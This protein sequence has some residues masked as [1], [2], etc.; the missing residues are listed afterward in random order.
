MSVQAELQ[1]IYDRHGRLTP[2]I[3]VEEASD[4]DHP[5]HR[6]FEWDDSEAARKYR[7]SQAGSLIRSVTVVVE[8]PG[9]S[10]PIEVRAF[11]SETDMGRG[12]EES[13]DTGAYLPVEEVID[14][15]VLRSAWFRSLERDWQR[16]R[17]RAGD[18]Q[19][20][21]QMVLADVREIAG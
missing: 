19:E 7:L 20:F 15:D 18:S 13:P 4:P 5:V 16:L 17:R 6:R 1:E 8:K 10:E 12:R 2:A 9:H 11:I 14:N 21:A 3:V